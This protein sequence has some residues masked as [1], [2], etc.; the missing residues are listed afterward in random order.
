MARFVLVHGA[1]HGGWCWQRLT[2]LLVAHGHVVQAPDLPAAGEDPA[3]PGEVG[4]D[5]Y[6]ER[7]IATPGPG[8]EAVALVGHSM[9][10]VTLTRVAEA[11]PE[12]IA[13]AVYV[14]AFMLRD[15]ERVRDI[16]LLDQAS[17][18]LDAIDFD[19]GGRVYRYRAAAA[20]GLFYGDCV[21]S[22]AADAIA[23]L[24]PM[25]RVIAQEPV[26]W[27]PDRAGRVPRA[28]VRCH[29]DRAIAPRL[30]DVMCER[31]PPS[32]VLHMACGHSPFLAA[33]S[34]LAEHLHAI[35]GE[36]APV[37]G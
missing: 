32:R 18:V 37:A 27:S 1:A 20:R 5:D 23:R 30:Q 8:D 16:T 31:L 10:G 36:F 6:A 21:E 2:P 17:A 26:R 34:V 13:C 29:A 9:G 35:A 24:R 14:T 7:V 3:S 11:R 28:Y 19:A 15:G 4:G 12:R 25:P 33:P 22:D